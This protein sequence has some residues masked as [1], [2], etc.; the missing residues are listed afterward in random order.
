MWRA[1]PLVRVEALAGSSG[2]W[3]PRAVPVPWRDRGTAGSTLCSEIP[4]QECFKTMEHQRTPSSAACQGRVGGW[5]GAGCSSG[6]YLR[7]PALIYDFHQGG[8]SQE[9][10]KKP[11]AVLQTRTKTCK[12]ASAS[13]ILIHSG[14]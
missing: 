4:V 7:C 1:V 11:S 2:S 12:T 10:C 9:E 14:V 6:V 13:D 5:E 8:Y 3:L